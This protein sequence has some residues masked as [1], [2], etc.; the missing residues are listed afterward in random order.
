MHRNRGQGLLKA[1]RNVLPQGPCAWGVTANRRAQ[2]GIYDLITLL[3][4]FRLHLSQR[5]FSLHTGDSTAPPTSE[6]RRPS[7]RCP[8]RALPVVTITWG[9]AGL[10]GRDARGAPGCG[11]GAETGQDARGPRCRSST[12]AVCRRGPGPNT[13]PVDSGPQTLG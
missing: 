6:P 12:H 3:G 9:D 1:K 7:H 4:Y 11:R 13:A 5:P 10:R 8:L 2:L